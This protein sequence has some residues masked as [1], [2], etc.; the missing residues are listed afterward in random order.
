MLVAGV[1]LDGPGRLWAIAGAHTGAQL[2]A[3]V[4]LARQLRPTVGGLLSTTQARALGAAVTVA[5]GAWLLERGIQP[6]GRLSTLGLVAVLTTFALGLYGL[7]LRAMHALPP[8]APAA[9][10]PPVALP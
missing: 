2:I 9:H 4:W 10:L 8:R 7:A 1:A 3:M 5:V 6:H